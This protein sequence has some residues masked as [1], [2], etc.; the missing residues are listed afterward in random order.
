MQAKSH[1]KRAI[2]LA[3][4]VFIAVAAV[5]LLAD[6]FPTSRQELFADVF[7][8]H[9]AQPDPLAFAA[10]ELSQ[11]FDEYASQNNTL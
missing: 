4:L 7:A 1:C 10:P 2:A 8:A 5:A 9:V 3:I 6:P 11:L